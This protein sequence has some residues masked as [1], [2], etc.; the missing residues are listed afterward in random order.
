MKP[1]Y[2]TNRS[3]YFAWGSEIKAILKVGRFNLH[4]FRSLFSVM[5]AGEQS[6][7]YTLF[8]DIFSVRPGQ[9]LKFSNGRL[10]KKYYFDISDYIDQNYYNDLYQGGYEYC[11]QNFD[12]LLNESVNKMLMSDVKIGSFLSGGIDSSLISSIASKYCSSMSYYCSNVIGE[13]SELGYAREVSDK[14][15]GK[16]HIDDYRS[17]YFIDQLAEKTYFNE[18]PIIKLPNSVPFSNIAKIASDMRVKPILSGEGSDE[19]FLGYPTIAFNNYY[20]RIFLAPQNILKFFYDKTPLLNRIYSK[21]IHTNQ[22]NNKFANMLLGYEREIF[23]SRRDIEGF[24]FLSKKDN[25]MQYE[26]IKMFR[27]HLIALL[28][29]NDRMGMQRGIEARFPFLDEDIVKFGINLPHQF[30]IK[31]TWK[32]FNKKH[33][34]FKDK[35]IVR[36]VAKK[37]LPNNICNKIKWGFGIDSFSKIVGL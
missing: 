25:S 13:F 16:L 23:N 11:L 15:K 21:S 32:F 28:H 24:S 27:E 10:T 1:L 8:E 3:D 19:L 36:D 12:R 14:L 34:F 37:Y 17:Y 29:R 30:K 18:S 26:S 22:S 31:K 33:P 9:Y 20:K 6:G 2:F 5:G 4:G 35:A 7:K